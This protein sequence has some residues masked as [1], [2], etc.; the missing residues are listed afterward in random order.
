MSE[1][2]STEELEAAVVVYIEMHQKEANG[3]PFKK[4]SYYAE[5]S[6]KFGRS[7][8]SYEY[9]M[10]NISY[11]Y[12]LMG[13]DWVKGLKPAVNVGSGVTEKIYNKAVHG[14]FERTPFSNVSLIAP[15]FYA[16]DADDYN[17][18]D[19]EEERKFFKQVYSAL[20]SLSLTK[21][22][23]K[24]SGSDSYTVFHA[25][26]S[27]VCNLSIHETGT[28]YF[29]KKGLDKNQQL[30]AVNALCGEMVLPLIK[31]NFKDWLRL[32][33]ANLKNAFGSGKQL[34]LF[35]MILVASFVF[36]FKQKE[37]AIAKF[38]FALVLAVFANMTIVPVA[39]HSIKRYLF[40]TDWI[41]FAILIVLMSEIFAKKTSNI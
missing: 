25:N 23:V 11:V 14:H 2:W 17:L 26:Y 8:K 31:D 21:E 41:I 16:A 20:D 33:I 35:L 32:Y 36:I 15:A 10:Q 27:K 18:Y 13:R 1:N 9:R 3:E 22:K 40:Y 5:L 34:L 12:Q 30:I 24:E 19:S 7:T 39:V 38:I 28:E 6:E 37:N 29:K 4:T